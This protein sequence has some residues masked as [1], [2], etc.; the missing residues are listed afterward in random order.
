MNCENNEKLLKNIYKKIINI[1][2]GNKMTE[3]MKN[4]FIEQKKYRYDDEMN[5]KI[6]SD[7]LARVVNTGKC[8][9][10][11]LHV[12]K[13]RNNIKY[14]LKSIRFCSKMKK[15]NIEIEKNI[16]KIFKF[17]SEIEYENCNNFIFRNI[18]G[19]LKIITM[20]IED[21]QNENEAFLND[22]KNLKEI[23]KN[24]DNLLS[25]SDNNEAK[26]RNLFKSINSFIIEFG[27][28]KNE[29]III[30]KKNIIYENIYYLI[31]LFFDLIFIRDIFLRNFENTDMNFKIEVVE[32]SIKN[33]EFHPDAQLACEIF[34]NTDRSSYIG[35]SQLCCIFCCLFLDSLEFSFRGRAR[36]FEKNWNIPTN[37]KIN[38]YKTL[39]TKFRELENYINITIDPDNR[40]D[41][42]LNH[43]NHNIDDCNHVSVSIS[44]DLCFFSD[45][46][47]LEYIN[48]EFINE[49]KVRNNE[50]NILEKIGNI[51]SKLNL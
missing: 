49:I 16:Q 50:I 13:E 47:N 19:R 3:E 10:I 40:I 8:T 30:I 12:E 20:Q 39:F 51:K 43:A 37:R 9:A 35:V 6:L 45:Y 2:E 17:S 42:N 14:K 22:L 28:I 18:E 7:S 48:S 29:H 34:D 46:F 38:C 27:E 25:N 44:D 32:N 23:M 15:N 31:I 4:N 11:N 1:Y 21:V 41:N 24:I 33:D 36:K 5:L 26:S